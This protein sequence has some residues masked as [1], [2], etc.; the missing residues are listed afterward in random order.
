MFHTMPCGAT[1]PNST[2]SP[3][4]STIPRPISFMYQIIQY[5]L[6]LSAY[7]L[8]DA[9]GM[10]EHVVFGQQPRPVVQSVNDPAGRLVW[11]QHLGFGDVCPAGV[12]QRHLHENLVVP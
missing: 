11:P 2:I 12:A 3:G 8:L 4:P 1:W 7:R 6:Q 10:V 9:G 5:L